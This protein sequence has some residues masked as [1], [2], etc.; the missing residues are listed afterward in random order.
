L[1]TPTVSPQ[2]PEAEDSL[3]NT[4]WTLLSF[5]PP[6]AEEPVVAD[7]TVTLE[8]DNEGQAGGTGGCNS[9]GAAYE[10]QGDQVA[11]SDITSTLIACEA[12]GVMDQESRYFQAL[13]TA[14]RFNL[15]GDQLQIEY[16]DGQGVLTFARSGAQPVGSPG[17][18]SGLLCAGTPAVTDSDWLVCHSQT[19]GFEFQYPPE[20]QLL[21]QSAQSARIDLPLTPGT[22]LS[23]KYLE[24]TVAED[25]ETCSSPLAEGYEPGTIAQEPVQVND[26][27][28]IK[29]TGHE[30]VAG[31]IFEWVAYSTERAG[32]CVSLGF[33]LRSSNPDVFSTPPPLFDSE[34]ESEGFEEIVSTFQWV[35]V[36]P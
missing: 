23:E 22:N 4:R 13:Q 27:E 20:G 11:F 35:V 9:F 28:F 33:V 32:Q 25:A 16:G 24:V 31:S 36:N 18:D 7:T 19:Y 15:E 5:G 2:T 6:G 30:G 14:G 1:A 8:F 34:A 21:D 3:A 17:P 29:E 12:A 26:L 10:V